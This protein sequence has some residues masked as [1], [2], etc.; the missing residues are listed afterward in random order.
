MRRIGAKRREERGGEKKRIIKIDEKAIGRRE[1][2]KTEEKKTE[3]RVNTKK[4]EVKKGKKKE[5]TERRE[6]EAR[7]GMTG[8][9][10]GREGGGETPRS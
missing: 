10:E 5:E 3:K 2:N 4:K 8:E 7:K 6:R 9:R 1:E